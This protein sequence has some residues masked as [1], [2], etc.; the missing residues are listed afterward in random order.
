MGANIE[1]HGVRF[2][3]NTKDVD[4]LVVVGEKKWVVLMGDKA[5]GKHHLELEALLEAKVKA[6]VL[7][8]GGLRASDQVQILKKALPKILQITED[9][10]FPFIAK[11]YTDG[12]VD[13]WKTKPMIQKGRPNRFKYDS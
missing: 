12:D 3:H 11:V 13:I 1:S 7:T 5:I 4:W 9:S 10:D 2:R 6:F 8:R